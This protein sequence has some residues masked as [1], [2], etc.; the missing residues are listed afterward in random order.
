MPKERFL[1]FN[2]KSATLETIAKANEIIGEYRSEG[3]TLTLRQLYYQ[4]VS[5]DLIA[6]NLKE[7]KKLGSTIN[8]GRLAGLIDWY[9]IEDRT[10]N[11][12]GF[13]GDSSPEDAIQSAAGGYWR[14]WWEGQ[15]FRPEVW[16]EKEA[17]VGVIQQPCRELAVPYFACRGFVSQSEQYRSGKRFAGYM[18]D[19]LI[20]IVFHLGDH[21]PSG[22]DMTRDNEERLKMFAAW[23]VEVRRLALNFD[24]IEQY[25]PPPNPAKETDSRAAGYIE[26]FGPVSWE[27][28][29]LEPRVIR[30]LILDNV[31]PLIDQ[32]A[33]DAVEERTQDEKR[34]LYGIANSYDAIAT[35]NRKA[36]DGEQ[37]LTDIAY[38]LDAV[39]EFLTTI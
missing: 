30:A 5:R 35:I 19:G 21:D 18:D 16:I 1:D 4:F 33:W 17:L 13:G 37:F 14:N 2:F 34:V 22:M 3:M 9:A 23:G 20:P 10:R 7:Y 8:N 39:A 38:N 26:K 36:S 27:L 6:N 25:D 31:R 24:Q 12:S 28:D 29:A 11:L 32:D 15:K